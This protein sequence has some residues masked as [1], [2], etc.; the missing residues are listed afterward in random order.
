MSPWLI[1]RLR[2]IDIAVL[3]IAFWALI[4]FVS[5]LSALVSHIAVIPMVM[6]VRV[7][8]AAPRT[9]NYVLGV[10]A[11]LRRLDNGWWV[12]KNRDGLRRRKDGN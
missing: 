12:C 7:L 4:A 3:V 2:S 6:M 8:R 9:D 11:R 10:V 1:F 5:D